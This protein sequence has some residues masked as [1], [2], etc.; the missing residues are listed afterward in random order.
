MQ[1]A[2]ADL[3]AVRFAR[4]PDAATGYKELNIGGGSRH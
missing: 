3:A 1:I 2:I 4:E